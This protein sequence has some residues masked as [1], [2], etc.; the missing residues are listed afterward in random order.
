MLKGSN[1]VLP[2]GGG[3]P[4]N[5]L[6]TSRNLSKYFYQCS[7][8]VISLGFSPRSCLRISLTLEKRLK[9]LILILSYRCFLLLELLRLIVVLLKLFCCFFFSFDHV[10]QGLEIRSFWF[11]KKTVQLKTALSEVY[12]YVVNGFFFQETV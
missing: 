2:G 9:I 8:V 6:L 10:Q 11:Q 1:C 3:N 4:G 5:V 7:D 12:T